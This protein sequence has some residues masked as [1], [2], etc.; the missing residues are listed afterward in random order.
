M[1]KFVFSQTDNFSHSETKSDTSGMLVGKVMRSDLQKGDF[2]IAFIEEYKNYSPASTNL[3][4]LKNSIFN[5]SIVIV[6]ATW[7]S[8]SRKQVPAFFKILDQL[9]YKTSHVEI[10]CVDRD[11]KAPGYDMTELRIE[12]VPTFILYQHGR[13]T[14]RIIESPEITLEKDL[15]NILND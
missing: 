6:M 15:V 3:E 11:K 9:D 5:T 13:E 10:I 4:S 7:C 8:D 12:L 2:G 14:G 1:V